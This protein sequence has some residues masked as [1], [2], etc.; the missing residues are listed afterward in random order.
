[1]AK[2]APKKD[3]N[4]LAEVAGSVYAGI[5][6]VFTFVVLAVFPLY[7]HNYY[8]DILK[9][10]YKFYWISVVVMAVICLIV[11]IVFLFV[12]RMEY[13][14][15]NTKRFF[16]HFRPENLK[17]QPAAYKFL[18]LFII[19][20]SLSTILS[21]YKFESFWGNEGRF[22]GLFLICLYAL[23]VF[24][25]G[26]FGKIKKWHLDLFLLAGVLACLFGIT[27]Y[28]RMDVLSWKEGVKSTQLDSAWT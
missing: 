24:M 17:K 19:L 10:K 4:A 8:F 11:A 13:E 12:D 15:V 27:D 3:P 18:I 28:F 9:A 7:Y 25:I 2:A 16:S 23:S 21:D 20:A 6:A 26:K 1:M 14:G 22:S 5:M